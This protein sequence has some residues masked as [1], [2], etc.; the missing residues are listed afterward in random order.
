[1]ATN[2]TPKIPGSGV[3]IK[4]TYSAADLKSDMTKLHHN[5]DIENLGN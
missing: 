3:Y 5:F 1:M 2:E 4:E